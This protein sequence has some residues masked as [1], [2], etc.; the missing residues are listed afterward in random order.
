MTLVPTGVATVNKIAHVSEWARALTLVDSKM[1]IERS[2]SPAYFR[3]RA[4]EFRTKADNCENREAFD[5]LSKIAQS[6]DELA[7]SAEKIRTAKEFA[8]DAPGEI[9]K[10]S[11][12]GLRDTSSKLI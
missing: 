5:A 6:Y 8:I 10:T 11:A 9:A 2:Y 12:A 7:R 3:K 4:E 1:G